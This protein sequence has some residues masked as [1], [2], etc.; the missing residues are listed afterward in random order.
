MSR[1]F[2]RE[3]DDAPEPPL[4]RRRI[5]RVPT[6]TVIEPARDGP[7][8]QVRL[9]SVVVV[10]DAEGESTYRIVAAE[11]AEPGRGEISWLAPLAQAL[12]H[13]RAGDRVRFRDEDLYL[14]RVTNS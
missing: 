4:P 14:V 7:A 1:A 6:G 13:R 2:I 11:E 3:R 12:L 5:A 8:D 9:G 10:R